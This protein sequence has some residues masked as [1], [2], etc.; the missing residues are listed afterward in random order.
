MNPFKF[1]PGLHCVIKAIA[2]GQAS[3][4]AIR[5][6]NACRENV[7]LYVSSIRY[8]SLPMKDAGN[9]RLVMCSNMHTA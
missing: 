6:R 4:Y 5:W 8:P 9:S 7:S 1:L 2:A 3:A